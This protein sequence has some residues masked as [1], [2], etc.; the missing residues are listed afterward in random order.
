MAS[1]YSALFIYVCISLLL[2]SHVA[3]YY[4]TTAYASR[5]NSKGTDY[6]TRSQSTALHQ[7]LKQI[8]TPLHPDA[9]PIPPPQR[10]L[11]QMTV[12]AP[13]PVVASDPWLLLN[14]VSFTPWFT[15]VLHSFK[16]PRAPTQ[17]QEVHS[18]KDDS[19]HGKTDSSRASSSSSHRLQLNHQKVSEFF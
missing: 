6:I 1:L 5:E 18:R 11:V 15:A 10:S 3:E 9:A 2:P 8:L 16:R 17:S 14:Q 4:A 7:V 13:A 19:T 12:L